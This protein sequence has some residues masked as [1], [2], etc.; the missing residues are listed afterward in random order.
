MHV[1]ERNGYR[2][3]AGAVPERDGCYYVTAELFE[4]NR[5]VRGFYRRMCAQASAAN[6]ERE[7]AEDVVL[8]SSQAE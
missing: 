7:L 3:E 4:G 5:M 2:V 6:A 8:M 1:V